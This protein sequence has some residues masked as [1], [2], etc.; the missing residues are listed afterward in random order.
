MPTTQEINVCLQSSLS[1]SVKIEV[2]DLNENVI[3]EISELATDGSVSI[4]TQSTIRRSCDIKFTLNSTTMINENS[5][6]WINKRFRLYTGILD[7]MTNEIV[8]FK[9][10]T[11]ILADPSKDIQVNNRTVDIKGY[12]KMCLQDNSLSGQLLNKVIIPVNTPISDA[13]LTT[14]TTLGLENPSKCLIDTSPYSTPYEINVNVGST[15]YDTIKILQELYLTWKCFYDTESNFR[16]TQI[17]SGINDPIVFNFSDYPVIKNITQNILYSNAKNNYR[18]IGRLNQDG[19]QYTSSLI[20]SES[21]YNG[22]PFT[23]E[24]LGGYRNWVVSEE[25]LYTL[26]QVTDRRDYEIYKHLNL[27]EGVSFTCSILPFLDVDN[28]IY[29][30]MPEFEIAGTFMIDSIDLPL[31]F[32]GLMN[33]S[34]H[35]IYS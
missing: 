23:V 28:L 26:E 24:Q 12:D 20:V 17:K 1:R 6:L 35:R 10:G 34:A 9:H 33:I 27:C 7:L 16:F 30:D 5:S 13:V 25:K 11:F 22:N 31:K 29:V 3:D 15:V 32:D 18:V 21:N 19:N 14:I 4:N 8:W 2:L